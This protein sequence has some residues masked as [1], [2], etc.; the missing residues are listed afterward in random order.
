MNTQRF[1]GDVGGNSSTPAKSSEF[2]A[3]R[4]RRKLAGF[5]RKGYFLPGDKCFLFSREEKHSPSLC[6]VSM[7]DGEDSPDVK[8]GSLN[9]LQGFYLG[10]SSH[11]VIWGRGAAAAGARPWGDG[12]GISPSCQLSRS[13]ED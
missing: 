3:S 1:C 10:T 2:R 12:A 6:P 11:R 4:S 8:T 7:E 9:C 5:S 13:W